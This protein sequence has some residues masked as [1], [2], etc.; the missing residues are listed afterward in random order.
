MK[1]TVRLRAVSDLRQHV[2]QAWKSVRLRAA[3]PAEV[4]P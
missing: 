2:G 3:R 1:D 4:A